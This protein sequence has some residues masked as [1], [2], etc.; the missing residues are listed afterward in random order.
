MFIKTD[1]G[2]KTFF[3][4]LTVHKTAHESD[5]WIYIF[6]VLSCYIL[7]LFMYHAFIASKFHIQIYFF[8]SNF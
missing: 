8:I 2:V 1:I 6:L 3:W 5:I 7:I 4:A